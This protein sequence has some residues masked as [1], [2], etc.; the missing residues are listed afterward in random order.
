MGILWA[1]AMSTIR[2]T[3]SGGV[4]LLLSTARATAPDPSGT[5]ASRCGS[6]GES[7][8]TKVSIAK[9]YD[10]R[11][12]GATNADPTSP[13]SSP[14]TQEK[15][16]VFGIL[17]GSILLI[18]AMSAATPLRSSIDRAVARFGPSATSD[19]RTVAESPPATPS[20][21]VPARVVVPK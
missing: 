11:R 13:I 16:T 6:S 8:D 19:F 7:D 12:R 5:C 15:V 18:A 20:A 17:A 9:T 1:R 3:V 10:G 21:S 2:A 14:T 4:M